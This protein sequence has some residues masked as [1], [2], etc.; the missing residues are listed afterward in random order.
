MTEALLSPRRPVRHAREQQ[1]NL[2]TRG[3]VHTAVWSQ[4]VWFLMRNIH[5]VEYNRQSV[6]NKPSQFVFTAL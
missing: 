1:S 3:I 5:L 4:L 2:S 6:S